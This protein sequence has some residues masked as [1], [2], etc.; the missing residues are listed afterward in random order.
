MCNQARRIF[1]QVGLQRGWSLETVT[2][3]WRN[4]WEKRAGTGGSQATG[5]PP[6][7]IAAFQSVRDVVGKGYNRTKRLQLNEFESLWKESH[8]WPRTF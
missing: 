8:S 2:E 7:P 5:E 4:W 6:T 1:L 3:G